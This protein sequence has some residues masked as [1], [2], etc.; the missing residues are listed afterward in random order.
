MMRKMECLPIE[1][2]TIESIILC[3]RIVFFRF[4]LYIHMKQLYKGVGSM[5]DV[6]EIFSVYTFVVAPLS[7]I[8]MLMRDA[9]K[10]EGNPQIL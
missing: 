5:F 9:M 10:I 3:I 6:G 1:T 4:E 8:R 2:Y 7:S